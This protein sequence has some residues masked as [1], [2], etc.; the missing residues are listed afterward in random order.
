MSGIRIPT[1]SHLSSLS[2]TR[3]FLGIV[4]APNG[5]IRFLFFPLNNSGNL[6]TLFEVGLI[7]DPG[8]KDTGYLINSWQLTSMSVFDF[9]PCVVWL[10]VFTKVKYADLYLCIFLKIKKYACLFVCVLMHNCAIAY[11]YPF[12]AMHL[13]GNEHMLYTSLVQ[14]P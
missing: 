6:A 9:R 2:V 10:C 12:P 1:V 4:G 5:P 3:A 14:I 13:Y 8:K 11:L 7:I